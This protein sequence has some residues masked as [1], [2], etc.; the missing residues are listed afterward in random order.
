MTRVQSPDQIQGL[1]T[2]NLADD[3]A[4]RSEAER[5]SEETS[6]RDLTDSFLIGRVGLETDVMTG[7]LQLCRVLDR[8]YS[9]GMRNEAGE[10]IEQSRLACAGASGDEN[11]L[12]GT[13]RRLQSLCL[14][15]G[16][17]SDSHQLVQ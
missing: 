10:E 2:A 17:R 8:D 13:Y 11:G 16:G 5:R 6:D 4:I 14:T 9:L 1:G 12:S 7:Y 3:D 15:P